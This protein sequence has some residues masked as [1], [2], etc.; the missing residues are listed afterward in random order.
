MLHYS[1]MI[2]VLKWKIWKGGSEV[3]YMNMEE[4]AD[5]SMVI[6]KDF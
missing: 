5:S 3:S 2:D 6:L 4:L 1:N